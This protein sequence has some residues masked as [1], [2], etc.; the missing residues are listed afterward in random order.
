MVLSS[1]RSIARCYRLVDVC[2]TT[3]FF[4]SE[5]VASVPLSFVAAFE[6]SLIKALFV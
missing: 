2:R 4:L 3:M 1:E 5:S 6:Q